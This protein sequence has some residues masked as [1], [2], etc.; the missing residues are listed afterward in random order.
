[1][2][3]I[4]DD[5]VFGVQL[6]YDTQMTSKKII[7]ALKERDQILENIGKLFTEIDMVKHRLDAT[8]EYEQEPI[9]MY[10]DG[11]IKAKSILTAE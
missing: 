2:D 5:V 10:L 3:E 8:E 7:E 1:M 4:N 11:L 9:K 6:K